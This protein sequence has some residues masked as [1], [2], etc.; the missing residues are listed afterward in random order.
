M[1]LKPCQNCGKEVKQRYSSKYKDNFWLCE[2]CR[3][4]EE[5]PPE[6]KVLAKKFEELIV[7]TSFNVEGKKVIKYIDIISAEVIEG[8]SILK[9]IG[10]GLADVFGGSASSYEKALDSM[11]SKAIYK[12]KEKAYNLGANAVI[13][14][15]LD[16]GDLRGSMLMLVVNGTAVLVE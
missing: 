9:D 15:D 2:E 13:G 5:T 1:A 7:T 6:L 12:L 11:K 14:V 10:A 16:Y 4:T 8:L 3:D